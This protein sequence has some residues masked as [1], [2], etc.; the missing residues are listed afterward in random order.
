MTSAN[1]AGASDPPIFTAVLT[2][3][4]SLGPRGF[5]VVM[6]VMAAMSA[7]TGFVFWRLGAW[8]VPG[9]MGL[10]VL[11]VYCAFRL[12]Y[13]QAAAAE[14]IR[15][16]RYLL[17]VRRVA[18]D[19][20]SAATGLNPYWARLEI[21]RHPEFGILRMAIAWQNHRLAIGAFL[22]PR[23]REVFARDLSAALSVARARLLP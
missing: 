10:D 1:G 17:T 3:H 4:R 11:L 16:T 9:F 20:R 15:L 7:A 19:G 22:A 14:E 21:D 2:P 12:S 23:E 5:A 6:A 18:P 13:R 8:P